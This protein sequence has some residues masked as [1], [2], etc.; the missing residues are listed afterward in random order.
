[1]VWCEDGDELQSQDNTATGPS[2]QGPIKLDATAAGVPLQ[3]E[4]GS[5]DEQKSQLSAAKL[6]S[7]ARITSGDYRNLQI[8]PA[9]TSLPKQASESPMSKIGERLSTSPR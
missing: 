5:S 8:V 2:S 9:A 6:T 4:A 3:S 1:M 7:G